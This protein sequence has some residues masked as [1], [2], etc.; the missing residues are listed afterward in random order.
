MKKELKKLFVPSPPPP[1]P[2]LKSGFVK[3][4]IKEGTE[5]RSPT[6]GKSVTVHCT[7]YGKDGDLSVPFWST[8]DKG[9]TTFTFNIGRG[10]V[11]KCWDEGCMTMKVGE[12]ARITCSP[13]YGYGAEG[14]EAWGIMPNSELIFEIELL[15]C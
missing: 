4:I 7:G 14:F 11:I 6:R 8:K 3:Q 10:Q 5:K 1:P 9:Q 13:D 2:P 15:K 12:I